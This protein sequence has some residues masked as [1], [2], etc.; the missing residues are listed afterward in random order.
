MTK[1]DAN[2]TFLPIKLYT[3][4]LPYDIGLFYDWCVLRQPAHRKTKR[5]PQRHIWCGNFERL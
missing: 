3:I 4:L 2:L 5:P 1:K